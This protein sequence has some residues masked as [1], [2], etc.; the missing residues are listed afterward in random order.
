MISVRHTQKMDCRCKHNYEG[1]EQGTFYLKL[2]VWWRRGEGGR[3][4][5]AIA[6][7][8]SAAVGQQAQCF[9]I[10]RDTQ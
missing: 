5:E 3:E 6:R 4:L 1:N 8:E 7:P 2:S 9:L 10:C